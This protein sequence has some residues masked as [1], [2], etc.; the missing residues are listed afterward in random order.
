ML[1][2]MIQDVFERM[3]DADQPPARV[4]ISHAIRQARARRRRQRLTVAGAPF[5]AAGAALAV[6]LTGVI[7]SGLAGS[8]ATNWGTATLVAP[9]VFNPLRPYAAFGWLPD[10]ASERQTTGLFGQ[11][12]LLLAGPQPLQILLVVH[13]ADR[14]KV[15]GHTLNCNVAGQPAPSQVLG[16]LVGY[17]DGHPAYWAGDGQLLRPVSQILKSL[18]HGAEHPTA[19]ALAWQYARGGWTI[20]EAPDLG[21]ALRTADSVR[22]GPDVSAPVKFPFQ[23]TGVPADWQV[24]AVATGR[25]DGVMY[26]TSDQVTAGHVDAVPEGDFPAGAP[27]LD[28]GFSETWPRGNGACARLAYYGE[29]FPVIDGYRAT[30]GGDKKLPPQQELC[31][32]ANSMLVWIAVGARP[33]LSPFE[34]FGRYLRLLGPNP[35]HWTTRPIG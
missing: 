3:A 31:V 30:V 33:T 10:G 25:R 19:G 20:L 24:N 6:G 16:R 32:G 14:C 17:V 34:L 12:E 26:A 13:A 15:S 2:R 27:F 9:R 35:A 4:S 29:R 18:T 8:P 22:F 5:L 28:T 1:D 7:G 21:D 23:L 11:D